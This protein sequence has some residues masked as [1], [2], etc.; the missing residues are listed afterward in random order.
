M[1]AGGDPNLADVGGLRP[2][3]ELDGGGGGGAPKASWADGA[4]NIEGGGDPSS[5]VVGEAAPNP[6]GAGGGG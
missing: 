6:P 4:P 1:A 2:P 5:A 3:A